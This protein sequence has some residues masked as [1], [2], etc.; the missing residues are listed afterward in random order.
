M[1]STIFSAQ[2]DGEHMV[3]LPRF[4]R[5]CDQVFVIGENYVLET[6]EQRSAA[7]HRHY[8]ACI[9]SAWQNLP[10]DMSKQF[11]TED[12]LRKYALIKTGFYNSN[13]IKCE[14][15][16]QAVKLAAFIKPLDEFGVIDVRGL[17]VTRFTARSQSMKAMGKEIFTK[18]KNDVLDFLATLVGTSTKELTESVP[19]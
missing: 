8:F 9:R 4:R 6:I 18:S 17:V 7:S 12:H 1:S 14:T 11:P 2:W 16:A 19:L 15:P 10:E 13:A 5:Q 3:P